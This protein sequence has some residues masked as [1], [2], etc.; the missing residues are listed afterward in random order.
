LRAALSD[1]GYSRCEAI[2]QLD[3]V[4]AQITQDPVTY[5]PGNYS[6]TV[7]GLPSG[8][9]PWGW[10][11]EGHHL[12]LNFLHAAE[13]VTVTPAFFGAHPACVEHGRLKGLRV[14]G[15]EE[16]LGRQLV[17]SL[18]DGLRR[19]AIIGDEAFDDILTGP[20]RETSLRQPAGIA[21][22]ALERDQRELVH[23]I[24]EQFIGTLEPAQAAAERL[25][26]EAAGI[27]QIHFGWAGSLEPRRP[28]Y[29]RLHGPT[30]VIEYDN[31][32]NDAN[33]IHTVWHDPTREFGVDLLRAHYAAGTHRHGADGSERGR[34]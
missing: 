14:L 33:H 9:E 25:R 2:M 3:S 10:R 1:R 28:H 16:D 18:Q 23:R 13:S 30:V 7:F 15:A 8:R 29:Y 12:S 34:S 22:D 32:Q 20:G 24:I 11:I 27:G 17:R 19:R 21:V 5:D 4:V 26:L 31:T 6:V